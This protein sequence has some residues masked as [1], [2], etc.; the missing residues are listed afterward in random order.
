MLDQAVRSL[1]QLEKIVPLL[2]DLGLRHKKY[3]VR[4]EHYF[5]VGTT[6]L[7]TLRAK[8]GDDFT[9]ALKEAWTIVYSLVANTMREGGK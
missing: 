4:Q 2:R 8:L 5:I 9:P 6:L 3:G 1:C 7:D